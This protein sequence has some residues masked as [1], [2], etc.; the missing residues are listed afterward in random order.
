MRKIVLIAACTLLLTA[1]GKSAETELPGNFV[2]GGTAPANYIENIVPMDSEDTVAT[3]AGDNAADASATSDTESAAAITIP[4]ADLQE[5][6]AEVQLKLEAAEAKIKL[7]QEELAKTKAQKAVGYSTAQLAMMR[8]ALGS[9]EQPEYAFQSCGRLATFARKS[10]FS[11]FETALAKQ[12]IRFADG[13][14]ETS[15][16]FGGCYSSE[17]KMAF[18]LG[19]ERD[20]VTALHVLKF[21]TTDNVLAPALALDDVSGVTVT[22][23][24]KRDGAFI[25]FP[26]EDGGVLRYYYDANML[27]GE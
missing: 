7:L 17:G 14:L 12:Q 27:V 6:N 13:F 2:D 19:A 15:D 18:F 3:E 16:L 8:T 9:G 22:Q 5:K 1:C 10:W 4:P 11:K 23:F 26:D 24:G 25:R 20:D 21:S